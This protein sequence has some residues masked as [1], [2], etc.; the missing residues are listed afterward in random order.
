VPCIGGARSGWGPAALPIVVRVFALCALMGVLA[1]CA[2]PAAEPEPGLNFTARATWG[3]SARRL[4]AGDLI[5]AAYGDTVY[6]FSYRTGSFVR[7]FTVNAASIT[8]LCSGADGAVFVTTFYI[9]YGLGHVYEYARGGTTPIKTLGIAAGYSPFGCGVDS[10]T[11]NLAVGVDAPGSGDEKVA[12]FRKGDRAATYYKNSKFLD[13]RS[14]T[15]DGGGDLFVQDENAQVFELPRGTGSFTEVALPRTV[16]RARWIQWDGSN[17]AIMYG[18]SRDLKIARVH[19]AGTRGK[20]EATVG[21]NDITRRLVPPP[22]FWI[23]GSGVILPMTGSGSAYC[24]GVYP[25]P[26]GG[27]PEVVVRGYKIA[28]FT[29][30]V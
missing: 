1:G 21:F 3:Q 9:P 5:Y 10:A 7:Q 30:S 18:G 16:R 8:G 27:N 12:V 14:V 22:T 17:L 20:L 2:E 29:V 26:V 15:Y 25:Y 23:N 13:L 6:I 24:F 28:Y 19:V 11:G 4:G